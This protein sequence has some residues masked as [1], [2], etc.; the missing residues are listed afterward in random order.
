MAAI[1]RYGNP[2]LRRK[3]D[4]V[5]SFDDKFR[6]MVAAMKLTM[7][8]SDGVGLAAPQV[9]IS[10]CFFIM[11]IPV[12]PKDKEGERTWFVVANPQFT[13]KSDEEVLMEEGCLS[14]PGMYIEV[15]RP[16]AVTIRYQDEFGQWREMSETGYISRVIQHEFDHLEGILFIDRIS[17]LKRSLLRKKLRALQED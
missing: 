4:P 1:K 5:T 8:E 15:Y 10:L 16:E 7:L 12:D 2:V 6:E 17:P 11:G 14:F 13:H 9:G 3:T